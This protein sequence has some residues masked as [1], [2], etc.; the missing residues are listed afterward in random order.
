MLCINPNYF[1][2]DRQAMINNNILVTGGLGFIGSHYVRSLVNSGYKVINLDACTYASNKD[3]LKD[4]AGPGEHIFIEGS[5]NNNELVRNILENYKPRAIVHFAAE[6]HVDRSIDA[7]AIFVETN[8]Q[9]TFNLLECS[10]RYWQDLLAAEKNIFRFI[11]ISTDEVYGSIERESFTEVY[12]Y[13]PNSPY[14]AS[15]AS[16]NH[17]VRAFNKTFELPTIIITASN[18]YGPYQFPEKLIPLMFLQALA[19]Q[20]LPVYGT[21]NNIRDWLYVEDHCKAISV[22]LKNGTPGEI[23][24]VGGESLISNLQVVHMLCGILDEL[25]PRLNGKKY[26]ELI[27]FVV[28]RPGHDFRYALDIT[29]IKTQLGWKPTITFG[30]GLL[31]TIQWYLSNKQWYENLQQKHSHLI[32]LGLGNK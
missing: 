8:V 29:K 21:G 16:S 10:R 9:G 1:K 6:T 19:E 23:Y 7:A 13:L 11:H 27:T 30:V 25:K 2:G 15:K 4:L 22:V 20:P 31:K 12:P 17:F 5:I 14:S 24:N 32:R 26:A 28:D 3:N 18:N